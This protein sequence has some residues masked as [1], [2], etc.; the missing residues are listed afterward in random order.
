[1][2]TTLEALLVEDNDLPETVVET[3][4]VKSNLVQK[5]CKKL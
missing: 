3:Q 5:D 1:M 2:A 4:F